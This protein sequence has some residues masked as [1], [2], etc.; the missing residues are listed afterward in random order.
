MFGAD[1]SREVSKKK[2]RTF[3]SNWDKLPTQLCKCFLIWSMGIPSHGWEL[4][5]WPLPPSEQSQASSY[6]P[7]FHYES[8]SDVPHF[9]RMEAVYL[10]PQTHHPTLT[11]GGQWTPSGSLVRSLQGISIVCSH[12]QAY[13][14]V[15]RCGFFGVL[16]FDV[17][18]QEVPRNPQ[19]VC[20]CRP[21]LV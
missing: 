13:G 2:R 12:M 5:R 11:Y 20:G 8:G 6:A 4:L 19:P 18:L 21:R 7:E 17:L 16:F 10:P 15:L 3:I 14:V 9:L 1:L